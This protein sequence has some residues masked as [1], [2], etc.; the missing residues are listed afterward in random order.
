MDGSGSPWREAVL[1]QAKMN[2]CKG[3]VLLIHRAPRVVFHN[4]LVRNRL[5]GRALID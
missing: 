3:M 2:P 4:A 5:G 1:Y